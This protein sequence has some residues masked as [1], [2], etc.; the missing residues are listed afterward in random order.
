[1]SPKCGDLRTPLGHKSV[2]WGFE[3]PRPVFS[4]GENISRGAQRA[5]LDAFDVCPMELCAPLAFTLPLSQ[6]ISSQTLE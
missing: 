1:M 6:P 3:S 4:G 5:P 2:G